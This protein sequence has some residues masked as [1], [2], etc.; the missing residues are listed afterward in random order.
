M[1]SA[2]DPILPLIRSSSLLLTFFTGLTALVYEVTWQRT[3]ANFLGS[4]AQATAIILA[5]FL[6]G[7]CLGYH[8]FGTLSRRG[9][10][11]RLVL[12]CGLSEILIALWALGFPS[13][14]RAVWSN[15]GIVSPSSPFSL[16][17]EFGVSIVLIGPP[18]ILMGGT[19]PLL[20][21]GLSLGLSDARRFHAKVYAVNTAGAFVGCLLAGFILLPRYGL[22]GTIQLIG[23]FNLV[24]GVLLSLLSLPLASEVE[25]QEPQHL[26]GETSTEPGLSKGKA[27]L[28]AACAGFTSLCMQT[29]F[30]RL[31]G[32]TMGASEYAFTM[33]VAVFISMLALGSWMV[34][35][36]SQRRP[37][38]AFNQLLAFLGSAAVYFS[39][40]FWPYACYLLRLSFTSHIQSFYLYHASLF[41][42][43]ALILSFP[44]GMMG[45][46]MPKLF[47]LVASD[48]RELGKNVGRL[49]AWNTIGC[50]LGSLL[51][52]HW[53]LYF[54]NLDSIYRMCLGI[55]LFTVLITISWREIRTARGKAFLGVCLAGLLLA[56]AEIP[57]WNKDRMGTGL[58][59]ERTPK[60]YTWDGPSIFFGKFLAL[61]TQL[62]YRDGPNSTVS[63]SEFVANAENQ[64]LNNGAPYIRNL[65]VNGKSDGETSM[66]D[67]QTMRLLAHLP[68]LLN[69]SQVTS[70][71]VVGFGLGIAAGTSTLYPEVERVDVMEISPAVLWAA[72]Y[73]DFANYSVTQNQTVHIELG[74]AYRA[75]TS[76]RKQYS[77]IL[78]EPSNPWVTGVERLFSR[79]FYAIVRKQLDAS[80]IY[81]QWIHEYS[82]SEETLSMVFRTF[83]QSFPSVRIFRV[84]RDII[85]LGSN[86]PIGAENIRSMVSRYSSNR[87]VRR[88]LE[89]IKMQSLAQMSGLELWTSPEQF[90]GT[91]EQTLDFPRLSLMAARDFFLDEESNLLTI[92]Q[93]PMFRVWGRQAAENSV[94]R[95]LQKESSDPTA[96]LPE[97][98]KGACA[99]ESLS[100]LHS[101]LSQGDACK[102][103]IVAAA[104]WS[105]LRLPESSLAPEM[106]GLLR[107]L[108]DLPESAD[109]ATWQ[110]L[111]PTM[112]FQSIESILDL[113]E[114][115]DSAFFPLSPEKLVLIGSSCDGFAN[116]EWTRCKTHFIRALALA[117]KPRE[118]RQQFEQIRFALTERWEPKDV[119]TL[120]RIIVSSEQAHPEAIPHPE[121][122]A[123]A[124]G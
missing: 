76:S 19:L 4:A 5:V 69:K 85:L 49:Y 86:E 120:E 110:S 99:L 7:L 29:V 117:G 101:W 107:N 98:A 27:N 72:H 92:L 8:L 62:F 90:P 67:M 79:E 97:Y 59:R 14:Y 18:T 109:L 55:L 46:T 3:L 83:Y 93:R 42:L 25:N 75:L 6:G 56:T 45:A 60:P 23:G 12:T 115:F 121:D 103:S 66:E 116:E 118:S 40:P 78:S 32:L 111:I 73:F 112:S 10:P 113:Y 11:R 105:R 9:S 24:F 33:I 63:V 91:L 31:T 122:T 15:G 38:I 68:I 71:G 17:W 70:V 64:R 119:Q 52:G 100:L 104:A 16:V 84:D 50:V 20:T 28:V 51:G 94:F 74:D 89:Q 35:H 95:L 1:S 43:L 44:I 34:S 80:G 21:Q 123:Q 124:G 54:F 114:S 47:G 22:T 2:R 26:E 88:S 53:L 82:L 81:A 36:D 96:L 48:R 58:F 57:S 106:L 41:I 39:V 13:L 108:S 30:I 87:E 77:V 37:G 102:K 61:A 65:K